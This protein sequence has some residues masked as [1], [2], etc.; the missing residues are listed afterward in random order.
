MWQGIR[1]RQNQI[2]GVRINKIKERFI[3]GYRP[4]T[5]NYEKSN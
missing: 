3:K 2:Q 1:F 4:I 5:K